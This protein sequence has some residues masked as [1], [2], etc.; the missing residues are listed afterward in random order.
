VLLVILYFGV[1]QAS[2]SHLFVV[3]EGERRAATPARIET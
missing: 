3:R 1:N 2:M